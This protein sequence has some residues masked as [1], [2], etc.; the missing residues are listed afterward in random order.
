MGGTACACQP[1]D[2]HVLINLQAHR[3]HAI[4]DTAII[5][6]GALY[7]LDRHLDRFLHSAYRAGL[8]LPY[9]L[10]QL[11][12]IIIETAAIGGAFT[13]GQRVCTMSP[14]A[15]VRKEGTCLAGTL[16]CS[17]CIMIDSYGHLDTTVD[18]LTLWCLT[19]VHQVSV[20]A[21]PQT[22]HCAQA[23]CWISRQPPQ[24]CSCPSLPGLC[25]VCALLALSRAWRLWTVPQGVHGS[26]FL[27]HGVHQGRSVP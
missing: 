4:F 19:L 3:G 26:C 20:G 16:F 9:S 22:E 1:N 8:A 21:L 7:L 13:G 14:H 27:L 5:A 2:V 24:L 6:H 25:R 10:D 12:R 15:G 11:A 18:C 23:A 17:C